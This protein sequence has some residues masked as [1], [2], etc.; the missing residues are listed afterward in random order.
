MDYQADIDALLHLMVAICAPSTPSECKS[1]KFHWPRH[2]AQTRAELGCSALE[3]SLE[4]KLGEAH[5]KNFAYT[6]K[7][8]GQKDI[9]MDVADHRLNQ[10]H[11]LLHNVRA[12]PMTEG[13]KKG[14]VMQPPTEPH[15]PALVAKT[16][17]FFVKGNYKQLPNWM[18]K[19]AK[20]IAM[21]KVHKSPYFKGNGPHTIGGQLTMTLRNR[22]LKKQ[23][24]RHLVKVTF[25]A[26][27]KLYGQP[28]YDTV[29]VKLG[30]TNDVK[31]MYFARYLY[32]PSCAKMFP[33][34]FPKMYILITFHATF[35][36]FYTNMYIR[37]VAFFKNNK[38]EHFALLRWYTEVGR[39]PL[40]PIPILPHLRLADPSLTKSYDVLPVSCIM[41]GA[42]LVP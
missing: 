37:C 22:Q 15:P 2:W 7:Q 27:P 26:V 36:S 30:D 32:C 42:L 40:E 8:K 24:P 4:R 25:R 13:A 41:N 12:P 34:M 14:L 10:L 31:H 19:K 1:I 9:Q 16:K 11:D 17:V 29:R 6:N 3:K 20:T 23:H 28:R 5:K 38:G 21:A 39:Y 35:P 33:K 18:G